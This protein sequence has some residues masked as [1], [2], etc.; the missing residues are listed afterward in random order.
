MPCALPR[1]LPTTPSSAA[2]AQSPLPPRHCTQLW[3]RVVRTLRWEAAGLSC[4]TE[5]CHLVG[6]AYLLHVWYR[7]TEHENSRGTFPSLRH[8]TNWR[9]AWRFRVTGL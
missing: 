2:C 6:Q 1:R 7:V 9:Q 5:H 3:P 8:R 4:V